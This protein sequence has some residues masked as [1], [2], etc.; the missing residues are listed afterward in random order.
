VRQ[1]LS[2]RKILGA[3]QKLP[4]N[5]EEA[6]KNMHGRMRA[7]QNPIRRADGTKRLAGVNNE[8]FCNTG[9]VPVW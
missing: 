5:W 6:L 7:V 1:N 2:N 9:H 8:H 4:G 3:G